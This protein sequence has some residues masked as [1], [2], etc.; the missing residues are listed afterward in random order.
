[1]T[2]TPEE[3]ARGVRLKEIRLESGQNQ[4]EFGAQIGITQ[5][6]V[7]VIENGVEPHIPKLIALAIEHVF[8]I[9]REWLIDGAG[10]K[11]FQHALTEMDQL[12]ISY[13][14]R[15]PKN[16]PVYNSIRDMMSRP[17]NQYYIRRLHN[18]VRDMLEETLWDETMS[19]KTWTESDETEQ[20]IDLDATIT[21]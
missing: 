8:L 17:S 1:M 7:S 15:Y 10:P 6:K 4:K 12:V 5:K 13:L 21:N 9:N 16:K 18:Y 19:D 3:I 14:K 2:S 20:P 11:Y